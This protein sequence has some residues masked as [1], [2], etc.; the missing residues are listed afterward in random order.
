M[1]K[2]TYQLKRLILA[3]RNFSSRIAALITLGLWWHI[4]IEAPR[5]EVNRRI[6]LGSHLLP[7]STYPEVTLNNPE[8]S[9]KSPALK[10]LPSHPDDSVTGMNPLRNTNNT[11]HSNLSNT[12]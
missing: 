3:H 9:N 1:P 11:D 5:W 6:G 7:P 10:T 12:P 4:M 2:M 8:A